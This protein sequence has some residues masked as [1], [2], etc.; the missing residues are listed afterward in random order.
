MSRRLAGAV[1]GVR[2]YHV[3]NSR[4]HYPAEIRS[5]PPDQVEVLEWLL[6]MPTSLGKSI[7]RP[8]C[9]YRSPCMGSKANFD[10]LHTH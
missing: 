3:S 9:R 8:G 6:S 10:R 5:I 7:R 1:V 4:V 2:W